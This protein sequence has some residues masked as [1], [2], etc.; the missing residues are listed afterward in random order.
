M[1]VMTAGRDIFLD[2]DREAVAAQ[3]AALV[4]QA[5]RNGVAIAAR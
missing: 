5:K 2:D 3:L 4:R 1:G